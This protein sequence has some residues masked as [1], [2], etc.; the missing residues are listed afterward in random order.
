MDNIKDKYSMRFFLSTVGFIFDFIC[1]FYS[2]KYEV[3]IFLI[4]FFIIIDIYLFFI[5]Y[6]SLMYRLA[7][8]NKFNVVYESKINL[9]SLYDKKL[10]RKNKISKIIDKVFIISLY[11]SPI[12]IIFFVLLG[13]YVLENVALSIVMPAILISYLVI[14]FFVKD[15][16]NKLDYTEDIAL[17]ELVII[18]KKSIIYKGEVYLFNYNGFHFRGNFYKFFFIPLSKIKFSE[19][20]INLIGEYRENEVCD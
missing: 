17:K 18:N 1:A 14:L 20:L 7:L 10:K 2:I 8:R 13:V 3:N 9:N 19:E 16:Y 5:S 11:A 4:I 12:L 6:Q 15:L